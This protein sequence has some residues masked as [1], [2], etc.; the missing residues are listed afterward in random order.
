MDSES[1]GERED[2][3][4]RPKSSRQTI[5]HKIDKEAYEAARVAS[6][7][8][9]DTIVDYISNAVREIAKRDIE[10]GFA[11]FNQTGKVTEAKADG[12]ETT[13]KK[14]AKK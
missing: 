14:T 4:G 11:R 12:D 13:A 7:F 1:E 10:A 2:S 8:T 9:G 5:T 3:M 6:G